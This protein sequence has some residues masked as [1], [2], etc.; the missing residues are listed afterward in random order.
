[1]NNIPQRRWEKM[2]KKKRYDLLE[3]LFLAE[4]GSK[5]QGKELLLKTRERKGKGSVHYG[6]EETEGHSSRQSRIRNH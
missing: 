5:K 1:V 3:V 2:I 4:D 6:P